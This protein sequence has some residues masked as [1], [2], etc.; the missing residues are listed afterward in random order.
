[1]MMDVIVGA[2][3]RGRDHVVRQEARVQ[4]GPGLLSS[5]SPT[6]LHQFLL[7][8]ALPVTQCHKQAL[9]VIQTHLGLSTVS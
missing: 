6:E 2:C 1:M 4:G 9:S 8:L 3:A 5:D 7:I